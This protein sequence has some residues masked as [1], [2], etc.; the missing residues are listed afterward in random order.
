MTAGASMKNCPS[1]ETL[2]AFIDG[3]LDSAA[4]MAVVEHLADCAA[5]RDVVL[6]ADELAAANVIPHPDN[7]VRGRFRSRV[8][9][10]LLAA[11]AAVCLVFLVPGLREGLFDRTGMVALARDAEN[12]EH[13]PTEARLNADFDDY[14]PHRPILRGQDENDDSHLEDGSTDV[15]KQQQ[16]LEEKKAQ[17][18]LSPRDLHLLGVSYLL[19]S[20]DH[21]QAVDTLEEAVERA[22]GTREIRRAIAASEDVG[23]LTDLVNAYRAR[24]DDGD[25]RAAAEAAQRGWSLEQSP[26]TAWNRALT[27]ETL[28]P[29]FALEAWNTYLRL[30][31][32]RDL[33]W[34]KE[35]TERQE[36]LRMRVPLSPQ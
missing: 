16:E 19:V 14:K 6:M 4:K 3:R 34:A 31:R 5:C 30:D 1:D 36:N 33:D 21:D 24:G 12:I 28:N 2:A 26:V 9:P 22:T 18:G 11:A 7:V 35:A 25:V 15:L 10:A 8:M 17:S 13:R 32:D 20:K 23:L 29:R 27:M